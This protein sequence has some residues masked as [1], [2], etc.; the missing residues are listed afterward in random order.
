MTDKLEDMRIARSVGLGVGGMS[1][2]NRDRL[3]KFAE[4]IRADERERCAAMA[5][6]AVLTDGVSAQSLIAAMIRSRAL[7]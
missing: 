3:L 4:L 6:L 1:D 5:E 2:E 7:R